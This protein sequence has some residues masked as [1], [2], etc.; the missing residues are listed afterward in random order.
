MGTRQTAC[1]VP[2]VPDAA[3]LQD[4]RCERIVIGCLLKCVEAR[5]A[6]RHLG[7][8]KGDFY[9]DHHASLFDGVMRLCAGDR[10]VDGGLLFDA[11]RAG[12]HHLSALVMQ[13]LN[14]PSWFP[15]IMFWWQDHL[16]HDGLPIAVGCV[17]AA[18][19]KVQNLA[20][21]RSLIHRANEAIREALEPTGGTDELNNWL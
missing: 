9:H 10:P 8:T 20:A 14:E 7:L 21:R 4:P 1:A 16:Y 3:R 6:V 5:H 2:G 19:S 15:D 12:V 17:A 18:A 13:C 11:L